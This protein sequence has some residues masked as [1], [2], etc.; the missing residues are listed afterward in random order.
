MTK[1]AKSQAPP[2]QI[3]TGTFADYARMIEE[4]NNALNT[5]VVNIDK[6]SD[7]SDTGTYRLLRLISDR[8]DFIINDM[9]REVDGKW[10]LEGTRFE[11]LDFS[12]EAKAERP[13]L[14]KK[15]GGEQ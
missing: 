11:A 14:S 10:A 8:Y 9:R 2:R 15:A 5:L 3:D 13:Y 7:T 1:A 12:D 6:L 4:T